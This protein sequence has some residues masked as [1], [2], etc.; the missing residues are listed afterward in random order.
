MDDDD[1]QA[2]DHAATG[3][4]SLQSDNVGNHIGGVQGT[5][6]DPLSTQRPSIQSAGREPAEQN[7][8]DAGE[9]EWAGQVVKKP[10]SP[11]S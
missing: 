11:P 6:A 5:S 9:I 4:A 8:P 3:N 7:A 1:K 2:S 10:P